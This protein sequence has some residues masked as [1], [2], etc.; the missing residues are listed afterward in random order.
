MKVLLVTATLDEAKLLLKRLEWRD[1]GKPL[2][3]LGHSIDYLQTGIGMVTTA[4]SLGKILANQHYDLAINIGIAGAFDRSINL[5]EVVEVSSD[6]FSELGVEDGNTFSN[7]EEMGLVQRNEFPFVDSNIHASDLKL[8]L[9]FKKVSGITVN[10]VHG[11]KK[12]IEGIVNRLNPEVESMEGAAFFYACKMSSLK[13]IQ[14]RAI[15]NYVEKRDKSKW[16]ID[17]AFDN[18]ANH[19]IA[20]L[21]KI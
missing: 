21:N 3:Y 9:G 6:K 10:T 15:S 14:L 7:L 1:T 4:F 19:T 18:L 13:C 2:N 20:V 17:L 16:E 11:N 5:G 8:N 12:S